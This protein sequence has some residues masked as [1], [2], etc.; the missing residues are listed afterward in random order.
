LYP[1]T[2]SAAK[3]NDVNDAHDVIAWLLKLIND[4]HNKRDTIKP[5]FDRRDR[6][7]VIDI[8]RLLP[9]TNCKKCGQVTCLA[10]AALTASEKESVLKC[11]EILLV[12]NVD[13]RHELFALL[14]AG[15]YPIPDGF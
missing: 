3:I 14:R 12:D 13:K 5:T 15:G 4:C 6:L 8:V 9:G 1:T 11:R 10:F 2:V 7:Q